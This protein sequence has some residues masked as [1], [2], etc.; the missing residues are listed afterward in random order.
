MHVGDS[1]ATENLLTLYRL[2]QGPIATT[3]ENK[4]SH[5]FPSNPSCRERTCIRGV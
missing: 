2:N 5:S 4:R 1:G 3:L